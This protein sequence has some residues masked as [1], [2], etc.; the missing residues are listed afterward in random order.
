MQGTLNPGTENVVIFVFLPMS[1]VFLLLGLLTLGYSDGSRYTRADFVV[2]LTGAETGPKPSL[3]TLD[4]REAAMERVAA[5][6]ES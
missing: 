3:G 2:R 4:T 1:G 5:K 6:P